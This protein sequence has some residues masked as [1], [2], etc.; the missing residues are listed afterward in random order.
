MLPGTAKAAPETPGTVY[1]DHGVFCALEPADER[2]AEGTVSGVIGLL[3]ETPVF[4]RP[5]PVVPARV[6]IGFGVHVQV[7]PQFAGPAT[8]ETSHPPMGPNGVTSQI[9][10]VEF[11]AD[12]VS[13]NGFSFDFEYE[14]LPG[15]WSF[16]ATANGRLIY[17][18]DFT[19]VDPRFAPALTC[20]GPLLSR[21][22]DART[23][24]M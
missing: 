9:W 7:A 15:P 21:S 11:S 19:V 5:G 8:I 22:A 20:G 4:A 3:D 14:L 13:Y 6:G 1:F 12:R 23:R 18:V 24:Q 17:K 2:P 16:T 10:E